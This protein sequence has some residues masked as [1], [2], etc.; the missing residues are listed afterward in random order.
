MAIRSTFA[1]LN[2]MY[3]GISSNRLS[4]DTVG[5]NITNAST[6]G[7][8]RQSVNLVT[9]NA[10]TVYT[11]NG[12]QLIGT[13]DDAASI[14]RARNVYADKQY[15]KENGTN[16]YY[17][18]AQTNYQKVE[19]IFNDSNNT[20][21]E[22][23]LADF[24]SSWTDL[25]SNASMSTPNN[26]TTVISRGQ[27]LASRLS[28][29]TTQ[30]QSQVKA[31]Y[32]DITANVTKVNEITDQ[33]VSLNKNIASIEAT[34]AN[35]NDLRDSRDSLVDTLSGYMSVNVYEDPSN[36]MYTIVSNGASMVSGVSK[37]NL[38]MSAG[39]ANSTYGVTD[40]NIEIA[41]T[42]TT[43]NAG[44]GTLQAEVDAVA[45][46]KGYM[47]QVANMAAFLMTTF[48]DQHKAGYGITN[49]AVD[50]A[51]T[52]INFYGD[53]DTTYTWNDTDKE[54]T[55]TPSG[56]GSSVKL[57][58]VQIVSA[59]TVNSK[60]T[61]S[62]GVS[63]VAACGGK[64]TGTGTGTI[65]GGSVADS[66]NVL[67]VPSGAPS[68][69]TLVDSTHIQIIGGSLVAFANPITLKTGD[70]ISISTVGNQQTV[71]ISTPNGTADGSNATLVS[72]LFNT[73]QASTVNPITN[74]AIGTVSLNS[75]YNAS[76]TQMGVDATAVNDKVSSQE[77]IMTQVQTWRSSTSG[78]NWDEELTNMI[79]YQQGFSACSR[80]LNT[81]DEML[82]KL[83][84]STGTVGR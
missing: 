84:N 58:G 27:A 48:N 64:T 61:G 49:S 34:G 81:M 57:K 14:T 75:Y 65:G 26:R 13:G 82:D 36:G 2:T 59:L 43:F 30:M 4:L 6:P 38:K 37:L 12:Q 35:A 52:N 9:T 70:K 40:Y 1:G 11:V 78:V 21:I 74:R 45:K 3:R 42:G 17:T 46:D 83:I 72:T 47:D 10:D 60:L 55:A 19:A 24:Y 28:T 25:S 51:K 29:A 73:D 33:I 18:M 53:N 77:T 80:C 56:G 62:D 22:K 63:Y 20:G 50:P 66:Y 15:W 68:E 54:V 8:S 5:H 44:S 71:T 31:N 41:E 67:T 32:D 69:Y 23:S 16:S 7:Y 39:V 76:M 79:K